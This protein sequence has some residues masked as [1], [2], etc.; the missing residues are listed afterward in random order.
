[1]CT[2]LNIVHAE[3]SNADDSSVTLA[4]V[5][6]IIEMR[7]VSPREAQGPAYICSLK[8]L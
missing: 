3:F 1:M 7:E 5:I 2:V 6:S 4:Y 8:F